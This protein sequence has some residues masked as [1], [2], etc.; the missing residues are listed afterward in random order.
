MVDRRVG[1]DRVDQVVAASS[2]TGSSA[3]SPRRRRPRASRRCRTGCR[4]PPR[5]RRRRRAPSCRAAPGASAWLLR[6]DAGSRRRRRRGRSRRS[7]PGPGRRPRT[8]RRPCAPA[9]ALPPALAGGGDH[10]RARQDVPVGGDDE[11]G[12]LAG[13]DAGASAR[14]ST[15]R[16][17]RRP[18]ERRAI[19]LRRL[20]AVADDRL[21]HDDRRAGVARPAP[22]RARRPSSV[23]RRAAS[24]SPWRRR[25]D[26]GAAEHRGESA[27]AAIGPA[28]TVRHY[29]P[30]APERFFGFRRRFAPFSRFSRAAA[31]RGSASVNHVQP[32]RSE[33]S[34]IRPPI[35]SASSRAIAS[36]SPLPEARPPSSRKKRSNTCCARLG[37]DA[38]PVVGDRQASRGRR[39]ATAASRTCVPAG[40][41]TSAFSTRTRPICRTRSASPRAATGAPYSTLER[42]PG[43]RG[44]RAEL[45]RQLGGELGEVDGLASPTVSRPASSRDRSSRSVASFVSRATCSRIC[46]EELVPRRRVELRVV[47]QLEEAA[48]REE[49]RAQ[50]VRGVG[51]E[52]AAGPVER[53]RAAG[54]SAR[55]PRASWPTSSEPW[56]TTG[57]SKLAGGDPLGRGLEPPDPAREQARA[58]VAERGRRRPSRARRRRSTRRRTTRDGLELVVQRRRE[59]HDRPA[60]P[61][62]VR[63]PRRSC[64]PCRVDDAAAPRCGAGRAASATGS[65]SS[66]RSSR[67]VEVRV[68]ER[69]EQP[70]SARQRR[71]RRRARSTARRHRRS[72]N[73]CSQVGLGRE[74]AAARSARSERSQSLR[75][76][77]FSS[78]AGRTGRR[79]GRRSRARRRRPRGARARAGRRRSGAGS[80]VAEAVA[81]AAHGQDVLGRRAARPRASR[82]DGGR[83]RR[84]CAD[85]GSRRSSRAP[86]AASGG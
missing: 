46:A 21:R 80:P 33:S 82:A 72:T 78:D 49:R 36:P 55:T 85:R 47:E 12:A 3:G 23:V 60:R 68:G 8:R 24:R 71:R 25:S 30:L 84:S 29:T 45:G 2:A 52:L 50:L 62:R 5:A 34:S 27:R 14:R 77:L 63:R 31:R 73:C 66:V 20:E 81:D 11:A 83:G 10:V 19:D 28:R 17:S 38:G 32:P 6:V 67:C 64:S 16:S 13:A 43:R 4:S 18:A 42:V 51:D 74:R 40:V 48:E 57:S 15:R 44:T 35:T 1:L 9:S 41:W 86:R 79:S 53:A 26:R 39:R 37:R 56:S 75:S 65:S 61:E 69:L 59:Q 54:A 7:A 58:R 22:A 70:A 76:S